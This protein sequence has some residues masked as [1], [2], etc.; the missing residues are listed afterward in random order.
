M[1]IKN[2]SRVFAVQQPTGRDPA[3]GDI[4]DTMDLSPAEEFGEITFI[5]HQA[6][7]PFDDPDETAAGI[8]FVLQEEG[9]GPADWLLL[10]GNPILIGLVAAVAAPMADSR[11][12]LLQW[13]RAEG[14][15]TPVEAQLPT[16][17]V[18]A[19]PG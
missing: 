2:P 15:Y 10:V 11:L 3:S 19:V 12:R 4:R 14:R 1:S 13:S 18:P 9:F 16:A 8:R 7:N 17:P 6:H 5:L